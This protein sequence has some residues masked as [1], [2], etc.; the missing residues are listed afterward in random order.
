MTFCQI[1]GVLASITPSANTR[2]KYLRVALRTYPPSIRARG[3]RHRF[4]TP[5]STGVATY[6]LTNHVPWVVSRKISRKPLV[7]IK[8]SYRLTVSQ[9]TGGPIALPVRLIAPGTWVAEI[10]VCPGNPGDG[11]LI[12]PKTTPPPHDS[13]QN[14]HETL[15]KVMTQGRL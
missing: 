5:E 9:D 7:R 13:V 14:L 8:I 3:T 15:I 6:H 2:H 12:I 1:P 4:F 11:K 10:D